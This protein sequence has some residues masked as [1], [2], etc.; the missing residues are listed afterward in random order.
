MATYTMA[1]YNCYKVTNTAT[2]FTLTIYAESADKAKERVAD[3]AA[4]FGGD[5]TNLTVEQINPFDR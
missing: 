2:N 4:L 1:I 5:A 3:M